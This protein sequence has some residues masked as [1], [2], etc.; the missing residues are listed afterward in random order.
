MST[1]EDTNKV[2]AIGIDKTTGV[3]VLKVFDH[4]DWSDEQSHLYLL[5]EKINSYLRFMES[6]EVLEAYPDAKKRKL[7]ISI[8][9]KEKLSANGIKFLDT[10]SKIISDAGF[11]L[12]YSIANV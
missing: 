5:Q 12:T 7:Q 4:L 3:V 9:F 6:E 11:S 1:I 10:V 2:D 8:S